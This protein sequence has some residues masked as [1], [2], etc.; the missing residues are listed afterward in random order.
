MN[1]LELYEGIDPPITDELD[2]KTNWRNLTTNYR[3]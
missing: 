2:K 1:L 3:D